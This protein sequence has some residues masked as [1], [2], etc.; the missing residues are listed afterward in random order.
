MADLLSNFSPKKFPPACRPGAARDL[1]RLVM[2]ALSE[3]GSA[4][5]E[6]AKASPEPRRLTL[7][8]AGLPAKQR[9]V[10]EELARPQVDALRRPPS[11]AF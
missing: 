6:G 8:I 2:G 7:A 3:R 9:D 1:E 5:F 10:R 4:R 11:T